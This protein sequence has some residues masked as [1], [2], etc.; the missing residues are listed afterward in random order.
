[1]SEA[2]SEGARA[3]W[4]LPA[5][6]SRSTCYRRDRSSAMAFYATC[7]FLSAIIV[8]AILVTVTFRL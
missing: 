5:S 1:M 8:A 6:T 7:P 4:S 3:G 2:H